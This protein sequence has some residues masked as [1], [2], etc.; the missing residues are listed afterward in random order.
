MKSEAPF[1]KPIGVEKNNSD[2][3]NSAF[4]VNRRKFA[5]PSNAPSA[6][7]AH[8][9]N[10]ALLAHDFLVAAAKCVPADKL[11]GDDD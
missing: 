10:S 8:T 7:H 5:K 11:R 2:R 9:E 4:A 3:R 6:V 1:T